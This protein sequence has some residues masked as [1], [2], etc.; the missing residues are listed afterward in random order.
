MSSDEA[1]KDVSLTELRDIQKE[2]NEFL[3]KMNVSTSSET[4]VKINISSSPVV[5]LYFVFNVDVKQFVVEYLGI[6]RVVSRYSLLYV[7]IW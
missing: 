7:V 1:D 3:Q 6:H 2:A 4:V 5:V